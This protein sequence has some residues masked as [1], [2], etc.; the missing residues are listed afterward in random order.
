MWK[1]SFCT[2]LIRNGL[3]VHIYAE[4]MLTV[5][6]TDTLVELYKTVKENWSQDYYSFTSRD[7]F[8]SCQVR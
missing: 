5:N 1:Y 6:I 7:R 4:E 8:E 3:W 2:N